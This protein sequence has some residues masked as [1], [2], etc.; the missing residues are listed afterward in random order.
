MIIG[1]V[2][3]YY[4]PD[5]QWIPSGVAQGL[6]DRGHDV[7]V[8][9]TYPH[10]ET[11]R[12]AHGFR[13]RWRD[14]SVDQGVA[15]RRVPIFPSHSRNPIGRVL[16][17]LSFVWSARIARAFVANCDV[18]YV[19]STPMTVAAAPRVWHRRWGVPYVLHIQDLWPESVTGSGLLPGSLNAFAERLLNFW[20]MRV[21]R[22][23]AA[24]VS[25][26]PTMGRMLEERG[27]D[28]RRGHVVLNWANEDDHSGQSHDFPRAEAGL[29]LV[30]A[31]NLG[32]MQEV[33]RIIEAIALLGDLEG[34]HL[35]IAGSGVQETLLRD[36]AQRLVPDRITFVGRLSLKETAVL[37]SR[38]DFQLVTLKKLRVFEGTLPSKFTSGLLHGVPVITNVAGDVSDMVRSDGLGFVA[39]PEDTEA[40]ADAMRAAY[41][42]TNAER[43]TFAENARSFY[44]THMSQQAGVGVIEAILVEAARPRGVTQG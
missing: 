28:P 12:I 25:I 23:A 22:D 4:P 20:L 32:S 15:L 24:V 33:D 37:L 2:T 26:A 42:A 21:Y 13:Q 8:L 16:N 36:L 3:Q 35:T 18:I 44:A 31:G 19:Y 39:A 7:R 17:Y 5:P 41:M 29:S 6:R 9:T 11:G 34:L 38:C 43:A 30:Y 40:L 10:Y 1:I 27:I 14:E